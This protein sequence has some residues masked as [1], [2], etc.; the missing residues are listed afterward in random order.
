[1]KEL[2]HGKECFAINGM[3]H[4]SC[5][6]HWTQNV[7]ELRHC[8]KSEVLLDSYSGSQTGLFL[9]AVQCGFTQRWYKTLEINRVLV[10]IKIDSGTD[11]T[12]E[13][14]EVYHKFDPTTPDSGLSM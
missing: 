6:C 13:A 1:M 2:A 14:K 5:A 11:I 4:F 8:E 12:C 10:K 3:N 7:N 9:G